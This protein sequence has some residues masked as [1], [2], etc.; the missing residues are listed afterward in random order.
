MPQDRLAQL[1]RQAPK[2]WLAQ[3]DQQASPGGLVRQVHPEHLEL[4]ARLARQVQQELLVQLELRDFKESLA[5]PVLRESKV[6]QVQLVQ[7]AMLSA[8]LA[9]QDQPEQLVLKAQPGHL[10]RLVRLARRELSGRQVPQELPAGL[11]RLALLARLLV[12][13]VHLVRLVQLERLALLVSLARQDQLE[14]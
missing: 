11:G 5:R 6:R 13:P 7:Q 8:Q 1:A 4:P 2:A 12:R 14:A 10:V 3:L 9:R